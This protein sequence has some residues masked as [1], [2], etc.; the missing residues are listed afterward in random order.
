M[1]RMRAQANMEGKS[2]YAVFSCGS[3]GP[4]LLLTGLAASSLL[5]AA[6]QDWLCVESSVNGSDCF[7][8]LGDIRRAPPRPALISCASRC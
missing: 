7:S 5:Q 3:L 4:D 1:R 6:K 8:Q 2:L